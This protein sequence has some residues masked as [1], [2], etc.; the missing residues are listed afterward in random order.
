MYEAGRRA[1]LR[2][3]PA[4]VAAGAVSRRGSGQTQADEVSPAEWRS[5]YYDGRNSSYNP[6][7]IE[8]E[9]K[10]E[11]WLL[12]GLNGAER[13]RSYKYVTLEGDIFYPAA[14]QIGRFD[15]GTQSSGGIGLGLGTMY[16]NTLATY[17]DDLVWADGQSIARTVVSRFDVSRYLDD[18]EYIGDSYDDLVLIAPRKLQVAGDTLYFAGYNLGVSAADEEDVEAASN[19]GIW[20]V[21]LESME[22]E[23]KCDLYEGLNSASSPQFAFAIGAD[24]LYVLDIGNTAAKRTLWAIDRTDGAVRWRRDIGAPVDTSPPTALADGVVVPKRGDPVKYAKS[25][26]SREWRKSEGTGLHVL[27]VEEDIVA[28]H[29]ERVVRYGLDGSTVWEQRHGNDE[30]SSVTWYS[31]SGSGRLA[32]LQG[33]QPT[34]EETYDYFLLAIDLETGAR[35]WRLELPGGPVEQPLVTHLGVYMPIHSETEGIQMFGIG[36][37]PPNGELSLEPAY[38][39]VGEEAT[40]ILDGESDLYVDVSIQLDGEEL[41]VTER[42]GQ[43]QADFEVRERNHTLT[44]TTEDVFHT[45]REDTYEVAAASAPT[46]ATPSP[47]SGE[48]ASASDVGASGFTIW[49]ALLSVAGYALYRQRWEDEDKE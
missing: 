10:P 16:G 21:G 13:V 29:G 48:T 46:T 22:L 27:G 28:M 44:A 40:A 4:L 43:Y 19:P 3:I 32:Y 41:E 49:S 17:D 36:R 38:P 34:G 33:Y 31:I 23:W 7:G 14:G 8:L 6:G 2:S 35:Q 37:T 12:T 18:G 25:D 47:T 1:V 24:Q 15:I 20:A 26:G 39:T 11:P 45:T 42:N 9:E 5:S 30:D